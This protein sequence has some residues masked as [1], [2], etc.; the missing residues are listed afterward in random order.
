[1]TPDP[2]HR[3][4]AD[5]PPWFP[6]WASQ[7]A[8]LYFSGTTAAFVL[9]GNT[10]DLFRIGAEE[11][12][13]Y[14]VLAEFL[15]EQLF[16]RWSLVLHYDLGRGLRAFAGRDEKRLKEMVTL[17]NKKLGDL[18]A[19]SKDPAA[20]FALVD[21]FVRTNIMAPEDDRHSLALIMDQASYV[22]PSGEPGRLNMQA[23]S[24]LVT[25]LNW[26]MSP[27]VKRLNMA[28]MMIDEKLAD[29]SDRLTGNPHVATIEV[30]LPD[31]PAREPFIAATTTTG[32]GSLQDFSDFGA[33]E[34]AKLTAGISLTDL[35]V[36]IQSARESGKRLDAGAFRALKKRLLE[37]QCH[38][39]LEFIEPRWTLDTVVGHDAAKARLR[40]DA[41]LL[42]RGALDSLPMGYLL[43]GPVGTGKSFLAQCVSG[44]I[45]VPCVVLKN[46][47]SKYVGETEG[48]L[49]RVLS[50]LRAMGPVVVVVDEADA[51]LGSREA[52][53]DSGTSSRVFG[54]IAAQMGDTQY[55]GRIIWMLLTARPDLLPI[56]LKRQGRAEVHIPLFYPTDE[57]EIREMFVIM[58]KKLGS[59]V[60]LE[61]VP[62]IPQRG[63]LSGADI[64]GIVGRA[65]RSSILAGADHVTREALAAVV[66]EF[67]P[68]TQ[69][70]ERELQETAAILECTDRQFLPP[71]IIQKTD[72][73]GGRAAL[74]ARLTALKQL[75]KDL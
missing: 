41:A 36:L 24:Q 38:G 19:L 27:H 11:E 65:W 56:D 59:R 51:A 75:V 46:F 55:R 34:L 28:F 6:P 21:R 47:R 69:G 31:Q 45:G 58:A 14:G 50:V 1:M 2:A 61:D 63:Q 16:G 68:S 29:L 33:A 25:M 42:K 20:T 37:R 71:G 15:A 74:Q 4:P 70:L 73:P 17:A 39:L 64:E 7:L 8:D 22:F 12:S 54:M 44:E 62:P 9:H 3:R 30:P 5:L 32:A 10:Y 49:E 26:A 18:S 48:N 60:A 13:R 53:G 40:E 52:E 43:C 72:V 35:N 67:M 66:A 57:A 23:S